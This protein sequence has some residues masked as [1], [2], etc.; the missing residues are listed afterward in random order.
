LGGTYNTYESTFDVHG[1]PNNYPTWQSIPDP[2]RTPAIVSDAR[3]TSV[4]NQNGRTFSQEVVQKFRDLIGNPSDTRTASQILSYYTTVT[5]RQHF[6]APWGQSSDIRMA[7]YAFDAALYTYN[8]GTL[9]KSCIIDG[10]SESSLS[11]IKVFQTEVAPISVAES[12]YA[13]DM[14][15]H[16]IPK[17]TISNFGASLHFYGQN[18][19]FYSYGY[20]T[21]P[22]TDDQRYAF[23]A[24]GDAVSSFFSQTHMAFIRDVQRARAM[25]RTDSTSY[26]NF[27]PIVSTPGNSFDS[28][29]YNDD[30][31]YWYEMMYHLCLHGAKFFNVFTEVHTATEMQAVQTVLDNW[32]NIS[33]NNHAVPA[34]N[35]T[36]STGTSVE[37]INLK[38]AA[39]SHLISGGYVPSLN[40]WIWRLTAPPQ[41]SN[42][43]LNDPSQTDLPQTINIPSGSRG[44]WIERSVAGKPD[45]IPSVV[46]YETSAD[47]SRR[48]FPEIGLIV[49]QTFIFQHIRVILIQQEQEHMPGKAIPQIQKFLVLGI[50]F[51]TKQV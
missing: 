10:L 48:M 6:N 50:I 19:L 15:G 22:S 39:E 30:P 7:Y 38:D 23:S 25:L 11:S 42:Y 47:A 24:L 13:V 49:L 35:S 18:N 26:N 21:N 17:D 45:Y 36:G 31:S 16:Y 3:F 29:R 44:M 20:H 34:S 40:K 46:S 5:T 32:K 27:F 12:K 28:S 33:G 37:R 43:T 4:L 2:R 9:R 1:L 51:F 8:F 14:N 41:Y